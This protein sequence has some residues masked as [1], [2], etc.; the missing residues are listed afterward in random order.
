MPTEV[1]DDAGFERWMRDELARTP[2]PDHLTV[3]A[4][5]VVADAERLVRRQGSRRKVVRRSVVAVAAAVLIGVIVTPLLHDRAPDTR[6]GTAAS[7]AGVSVRDTSGVERLVIVGPPVAG[8]TV[9]RLFAFADCEAHLA[10]HADATTE[11]PTP[12]RGRVTV[13]HLRGCRSTSWQAAR[14]MSRWRVWVREHYPPSA[15]R[16]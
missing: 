16:P 2:L 11:L 4:S 10:Q 1:S 7:C 15:R 13:G 3:A 6:A 8:R 12:A 14:P 9:V 5:D